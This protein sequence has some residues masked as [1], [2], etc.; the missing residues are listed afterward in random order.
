MCLQPDIFR[1]EL[2]L[3]PWTFVSARCSIYGIGGR[4]YSGSWYIPG[5]YQGPRVSAS[6]AAIVSFRWFRSAPKVYSIPS[7]LGRPWPRTTVLGAWSTFICFHL[8]RSSIS[9]PKLV[10]HD[11][12]KLFATSANYQISIVLSRAIPFQSRFCNAI[13]WSIV[14]S[15]IIFALNHSECE[16]GSLV[17]PS[18][19]NRMSIDHSTPLF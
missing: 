13:M 18:I 9:I 3:S 12:S 5:L 6:H 2:F 15:F 11:L 1:G 16:S 19:T 10:T 14:G 7:L 17:I 4:V 8:F